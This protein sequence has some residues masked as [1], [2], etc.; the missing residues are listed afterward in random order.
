MCNERH[1]SKRDRWNSVTSGLRTEPGAM[2]LNG[3]NRTPFAGR[4]IA[5]RPDDLLHPI[6][7]AAKHATEAKFLTALPRHEPGWMLLTEASHNKLRWNL[8]LI[9]PRLTLSLADCRR[10]ASMLES[11]LGDRSSIVKTAALQGLADLTRQNSNSLPALIDLLRLHAR[12]GSAAMRARSRILLRKLEKPNAT[13]SGR[14]SR[15]LPA[16]KLIQ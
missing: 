15:T 1:S 2:L 12:S 14:L 7:D 13:P 8:A 10:A 11:Y 16:D 4:P 5:C 6:E 9:V 3:F